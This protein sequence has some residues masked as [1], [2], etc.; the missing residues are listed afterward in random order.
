MPVGQEQQARLRVRMD[1]RGWDGI[2]TIVIAKPIRLGR[3]LRMLGACMICTETCGSGVLT[4]TQVIMVIVRIRLVQRRGVTGFSAAA[5][6]TLARGAAARR[7]AS[8]A[9][10]LTATATRASASV[11][12]QGRANRRRSQVHLPRR[13]AR[14][15]G[16]RSKSPADAHVEGLFKVMSLMCCEPKRRIMRKSK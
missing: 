6:G 3:R 8:G 9:G 1:L 13:P 7:N 4:G 14:S 16:L 15:A 11:A 2:V 10:R 5:A 12:P